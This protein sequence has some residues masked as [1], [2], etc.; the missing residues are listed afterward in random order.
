MKNDA[1][2]LALLALCALGVGGAIGAEP[3]LPSP[4]RLEVSLTD[5]SRLFGET[6]LD[7]IPLLTDGLGK[8]D[9]SLGFIS[10]ISFSA[11]Q[12]PASLKLRNGDALRGNIDGLK[13]FSLKTVVGEVSVP[14]KAVREMRVH[15][16]VSGSAV[17]WDVL[18]FPKGSDWPSWRGTPATVDAGE[19]V[20]RGQPVCTVQS[21]SAPL[22]FECN[23]TLDQLVSDDGCI[24]VDLIPDGPDAE[25]NMPPGNV[26]IQLGYHQRGP[27]GGMFTIANMGNPPENLG[28]EPFGM[29][30]GKPY[31]IE[32]E[33]LADTIRATLNGQVFESKLTLPFK[34]FHIELMG[35]QPGN[36]WRVRDFVVH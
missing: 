18:P 27:G 14:L 29:Q 19:I 26:A 23:A 9:I 6:S 28:P 1:R 24:W 10:S 31:H 33:V 25:P 15:P 12:E 34:T 11:D 5:G 7:G 21:Y 30:A 36:T 32:I 13:D 17:E 22:S 2:N 16:G 8:V 35:W 3:P 4:L 20:L